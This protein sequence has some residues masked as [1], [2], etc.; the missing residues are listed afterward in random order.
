MKKLI[1]FFLVLISF[2]CKKTTIP[3]DSFYS[4]LED[5]VVDKEIIYQFKNSSRDSAIVNYDKFPEIFYEG[6]AIVLKDSICIN[7]LEGFCAANGIDLNTRTGIFVVIALFYNSLNKSN[8]NLKK[9]KE[10]MEQLSKW[11]DDERFR[12]WKET[13]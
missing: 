6:F 5:V 8:V 12:K 9:L 2:L 11:V 3:L 1:I 13:N 10:E 7:E 4:K